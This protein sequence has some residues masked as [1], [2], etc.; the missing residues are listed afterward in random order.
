MQNKLLRLSTLTLIAIVANTSKHSRFISGKFFS[1][2]YCCAYLEPAHVEEE[3]HESEHWKYIKVGDAV[4]QD[5]SANEAHKEVDIHRNCHY[6]Y[7]C[8]LY[9]SDAADE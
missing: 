5:A 8:L 6:L 7:T 9:T 2:H 3:F 1:A 4:G